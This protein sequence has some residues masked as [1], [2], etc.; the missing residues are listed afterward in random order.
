MKNQ[1]KRKT[2]ENYNGADLIVQAKK[3]RFL[4]FCRKSRKE[5]P[6]EDCCG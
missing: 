3:D 2:Q 1:A 6:E 5:I 4:G